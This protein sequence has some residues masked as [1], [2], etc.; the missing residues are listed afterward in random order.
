MSINASLNDGWKPGA[1]TAGVFVGW[2]WRCTGR[3]VWESPHSPAVCTTS[4]RTVSL[5]GSFKA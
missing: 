2:D 5:L 4:G 3:T 1:G